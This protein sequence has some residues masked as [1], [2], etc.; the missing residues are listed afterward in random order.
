MAEETMA[1]NGTL[2]GA[3]AGAGTEGTAGEGTKTYSEEDVAGL[4]SQWETELAE[5]L[6]Q[7]KAEGMSEAERLAKL[8][9]EE[10]LQEQLKQLQTENETLKQNDARAKLEAEAVKTLEAEKLPVSFKDLVM[11]GDAETIKKNINALKEAYASAVQAEVENRL[12]GKPPAAGGSASVT[13]TEEMQNTVR[14]I[15]EG[16]R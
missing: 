8:T 5:K 16:G 15:I 12:K 1:Q 4:K 3:A 11:A 7:A 13:K 14:K 10:K 9:A 6:K 2:E